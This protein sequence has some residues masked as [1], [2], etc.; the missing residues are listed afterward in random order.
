MST[1][2][3][4]LFR[5]IASSSLLILLVLLA[6][7]GFINLV[8]QLDDVGTGRFQTIDAIFMVLFQWPRHAFDMF[9]MAVLLGALFFL[10]R[11]LFPPQRLSKPKPRSGFVFMEILLLAALLAGFGAEAFRIAHDGAHE[12]KF[13]G[14][15]LATFQEY[16]PRQTPASFSIDQVMKAMDPGSAR[17]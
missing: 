13:V 8:D 15:F 7:S 6:L 16:P 3:R 11:R 10:G 5:V 4:Y 14:N 2:D 17:Q 12:G 9:P 1:I